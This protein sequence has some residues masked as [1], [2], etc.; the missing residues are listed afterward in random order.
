M[1]GSNPFVR[2]SPVALL[3][4]AAL[5]AGQ[6]LAAQGLREQDVTRDFGYIAMADGTQLS[7]VVYRPA[8]EG[9]SPVILE[10][11]PYGVDGSQFTAAKGSCMFVLL[12]TG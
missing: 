1:A 4:A 7:Y 10:F 5:S 2:M 12:R 9:K 3:V 11:S 8:K 6:P